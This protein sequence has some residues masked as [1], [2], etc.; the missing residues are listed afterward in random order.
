MIRNLTI[1]ALLLVLG[2]GGTKAWAL[3][4]G[5]HITL[6][7]SRMDPG[8]TLTTI[9]G[10]TTNTETLLLNGA[11]LLIDESGHFEKTMTLPHG[12]VILSLT[13]TE[14]GRAHV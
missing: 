7:T 9:S 11:T 2:Y 8:S 12:G 13:A 14:I 6:E 3:V 5:P 10:K 4:S 1:A